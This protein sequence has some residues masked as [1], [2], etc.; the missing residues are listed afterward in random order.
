MAN[1]IIQT[2][3]WRMW[4]TEDAFEGGGFFLFFSKMTKELITKMLK[5]LEVHTD[6]KLREDCLM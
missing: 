4:E 3:S 5:R 6:R 1:V 2:S